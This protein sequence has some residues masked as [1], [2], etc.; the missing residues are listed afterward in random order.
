VQL[1]IMERGFVNM[2]GEVYQNRQQRVAELNDEPEHAHLV[3]EQHGKQDHLTGQEHSR[4]LLEHARS[5]DRQPETPTVGHGIVAFGHSEIA[6]RAFQLWQ[7]RGC[8]EED[9]FR[10]TEELRS[11]SIG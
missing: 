10:A 8:P 7:D 3:G 9:W 6:A 2:P 11:R 4:Q 5:T 1:Q